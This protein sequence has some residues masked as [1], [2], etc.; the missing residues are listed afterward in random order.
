MAE[1]KYSD[2]I[3]KTFKIGDYYTLPQVEEVIDYKPGGAANKGVL[4]KTEGDFLILVITLS[5][6]SMS[7]RFEDH[8]NGPLF[9]W[10]GQSG[11]KFA[12]KKISEGIDTFLMIREDSGPF[13]FYGKAIPQRILF[14]E[15]KGKPSRIVFYMYEY[16]EKFLHYHDS[17]EFYADVKSERNSIGDFRK[18]AIALWGG[19]CAVTGVDNPRFLIASHIIPLPEANDEEKAD[20]KNSI[21]LTPTYDRLFRTGYISFSPED[22]KI[23]LPNDYDERNLSLIG[24]DDKKRLN[25]IPNGIADYL[26]YH[27]SYIFNFK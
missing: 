6:N 18:R 4:N 8:I 9:F 10:E 26:Q 13:R 2:K 21:I 20:I 17:F 1:V 25:N 27:N 23:L 12:E 24:V 14:E 5:G 16:A 15:E 3:S 22:G 19:K 7:S 11:R